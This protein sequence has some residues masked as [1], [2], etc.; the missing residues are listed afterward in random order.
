MSTVR[1]FRIPFTR[2]NQCFASISCRQCSE[3]AIL[4]TLV[5]SSE[6]PYVSDGE[7]F[8]YDDSSKSSLVWSNERSKLAVSG[9]ARSNMSGKLMTLG[10]KSRSKRAEEKFKESHLIFSGPVKVRVM[11]VDAFELT[12]LHH[13]FMFSLVR[14]FP[15][16]VCVKVASRI[17]LFRDKNTQHSFESMSKDIA[18]I[19]GPI[20]GPELTALFSRCYSTIPIA[21]MLD[22]TRR[23]GRFSRKFLAMQ[24]DKNM[25]PRLF[26]PVRY[27]ST[28]VRPLPGIVTRPF[29]LRSF[30]WLLPPCS[31]KRYIFQHLIAHSGNEILRSKLAIDA[32]AIDPLVKE[33][34]SFSEELTSSWKKVQR[35]EAVARVTADTY[36]N[37]PGN[38]DEIISS[39]EKSSGNVPDAAQFVNLQTLRVHPFQ[40]P[41]LED[42]DALV[43]TQP[44]DDS[45]EHYELQNTELDD[46]NESWWKERQSMNGFFRHNKNAYRLVDDEW[47]QIPDPRG[48]EPDYKREKMLR[49]SKLK[50]RN[51][52]ARL[53]RRKERKSEIHGILSRASDN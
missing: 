34:G 43:N 46:H 30:A 52:Y 40:S 19:F 10:V 31:A 3:P 53:T 42:S 44:G 24:I 25:N 23:F 47:K 41:L 45:T 22:Y 20:Y 38:V 11:D 49:L 36:S 9:G 16:E 35:P 13:Y 5:C 17:A 51:T 48:E 8:D 28:G 1:L 6:D 7:D 39:L 50:I 21:F 14:R 37:Q 15:A 27:P 4:N 29:A 26:D 18:S 2:R 12:E 32:G 33:S